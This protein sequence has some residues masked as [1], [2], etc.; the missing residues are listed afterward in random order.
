M[1]RCKLFFLSSFTALLLLIKFSAAAQPAA[2]DSLLIKLLATDQLLPILVDSALSYSPAVKRADKSEN[3]A[4]ANLQISRQAIF[5]AINLQSSY[6]YGT[7]YATV[8]SQASPIAGGSLTT[9]Q[10]GFYN[11]GIGIQLPVNA[12][13]NRKNILK[14]GKS[15][16]EMVMAEKENIELSIRQEVVRLYQEF[17]LSQ[18]MM[19]ISAKNRQTAQVNNSMAEKDF[20]NGQ[21]TIDR[22]SIVHE[23]YNRSMLDFEI[24]VNK[25]QTSYMQLE[26]FTGINLS[27]LIFSIK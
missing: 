1:N 7:N 5:S 14:A 25:F 15:Q 20:V 8:N 4:S 2:I 16:I 12:I 18:K 22:L 19:T 21:L 26:T 11:V 9:A 10:T 27:A 24:Y 13:I 6:F 3:L 23:S 17:K